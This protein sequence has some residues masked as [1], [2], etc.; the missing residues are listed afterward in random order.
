[1]WCAAPHARAL[2]RNRQQRCRSDAAPT[3]RAAA[4]AMRAPPAR[5]ARP[6]LLTCLCGVPRRRLRA[7]AAEPTFEEL[8]NLVRDRTKLKNSAFDDG[9]VAVFRHSA[10]TVFR[11]LLFDTAF[12]ISVVGY[13]LL[14]W[15]GRSVGL[16]AF[17]LTPISC[18]GSLAAFI[19]VFFSAFGNKD[20]CLRAAC[21]RGGAMHAC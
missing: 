20:A 18:V 1:M 2:I 12:Y 3:R 5:H 16:D 13:V 14:R 7:P 11:L 15:Y 8:E 9:L 4:D 19:I 10:K 21:Q 6:L 17:P